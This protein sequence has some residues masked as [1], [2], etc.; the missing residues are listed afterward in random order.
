MRRLEYRVPPQMMKAM[1]AMVTR[2][3]HRPHS[4]GLAAQGQS[5]KKNGG[6]LLNTHSELDSRF[7]PGVHSMTVSEKSKLKI[8]NFRIT[9]GSLAGNTRWL[10]PVTKC[11]VR[12][13]DCS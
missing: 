3:N 6:V 13:S 5:R 10:P 7:I 1:H 8:Q 2:R 12:Y 4:K 9:L 11:G